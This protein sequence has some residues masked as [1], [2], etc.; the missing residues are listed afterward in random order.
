MTTSANRYEYIDIAKGIG[1]LLVVWAHILLV[2]WT[3]RFIY[4]FHMPLF[5]FISGYLFK[6]DKYNSFKDFF[7][8]RF[9]RL[10][11]PYLIYS[12]FTWTI[13]AIF[14]YITHSDVESYFMPLVQTVIAQGSGEFLVH[15]SALWF[16]PCLFV[17]EILY[18]FICKTGDFA[19]IIICIAFAVFNSMMASFYGDSYMFTLPWNLDAAFYALP[20]YGIANT[21]QNHY[22]HE[23]LLT[24]VKQNPIIAILFAVMLT[25]ILYYLSN[26]F[27][28]C[29][30]G[31][32]SY[33]CDFYIFIIRAFFG[34]FA[35]IIFS[36]LLTNLHI[37]KLI[38]MPLSWCGRNSLDI[39]C[40][41]IPIKGFAIILATKL[42]HPTIE[43]SESGPLSA[44]VFIVTML[45]C[46]PITIFINRYI[47][48]Q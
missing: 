14:R 23:Q 10:I 30:M 39:M 41:H 27:R 18:Y 11:I 15:N 45:V 7:K 8:K 36:M 32:S 43:V 46:I 42:I 16:I 26:F 17:V 25:A 21:I 33:Q 2:G 19:A 1:I 12:V 6:R 47:R 4:A 29:S 28:E 35:V 40:L 48:K 31:S 20:F 13:W 37:P 44:I 9:K 3:H 5:F 24:K 22:S 38:T 34:C